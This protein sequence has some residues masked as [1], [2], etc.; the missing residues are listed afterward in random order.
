MFH[1]STFMKVF[2]REEPMGNDRKGQPTIY[3]VAEKAGVSITT[4]SRFLNNSSNISAKTG[5]R[6]AHAIEVL[7]YVPHGNTGTRT[8]R[9]VGRVGVLTPFFP[10]PSFIERLEGMTPVFKEHNYEMVIYTIEGPEQLN[11]YL[12]S[13]PFTKR[14]D[15]LILM[16]VKLS[17]EQHRTL[18]S[19]GLQ[20]V[21]VESDDDNYSRVLADD[22]R[23][24][25]L[26]ARCFLE[27][28][29]FPCAYIGDKPIPYP[30][31]LHP[32]ELRLSGFRDC[33]E[34]NGRTIQ[35]EML[36]QAYTT[37]EDSRLVLGEFLD[38]GN[39]PRAVF[40]MSDIHAIGLIKAAR[41]RGIRIPQDMAVL[42]FDDI[43][44]ASW[45]ELS[46]I[47]QHLN[48]S[49]R[50]AAELLVSQIRS[51]NKAIQKVKLQVELI[52]RSTT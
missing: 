52:E 25:E 11:E 16:S 38:R 19:S 21:L 27:K 8:N 44:G 34:S 5:Q 12:T 4:V 7:D 39:R 46:T 48:D 24:G 23:G 28:D 30:Y 18:K 47:S 6:I 22:Y 17:P 50:I 29:Y 45:M 13:V 2:S 31:N 14:I 37:V 41:E 26:A 9:T 42:G 20:V 33:L 1:E 49:G 32:S 40:A 3:D 51:N 35:K 10:A 43:E 36:I 15:G